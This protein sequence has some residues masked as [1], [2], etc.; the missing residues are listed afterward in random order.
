ML[1]FDTATPAVTVA[2]HDGVSALASSTVVNAR[3]HGELLA[4]GIEKV[5][6]EAY[7]APQEL[8][9]VAVGVGPG[10]YTGL[11]VGLATARTFGSVLGLP[12][13][14]ACTLDVLAYESML[15]EP[16][17][18]ATDARRG[19]VYLATYTGPDRRQ[20]EPA[21]AKPADVRA[22]GTANGVAAGSAGSGGAGS[23]D[24]SVAASVDGSV[25]TSPEGGGKARA[26]GRLEGGAGAIPAVGEGALLYPEAFPDARPPTYP[27]A[28]ALARLVCD[29]LEKGEG[30]LPP[31][32][33]YLRRPHAGTPGPRKQVRTR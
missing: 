30:L 3:R 11:R 16:F 32:P 14:G 10:P 13:H 20:A 1:A 25:E 24:T 7:A 6:G 5:L 33:L 15:P 29:R 23:V 21:V 22:Y 19:E 27:S 26:G 17:A 12:V 31:E 4:P 2:L 28:V 8:T 18:V 9:H